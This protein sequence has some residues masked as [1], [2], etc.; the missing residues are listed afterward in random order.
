M[1]QQKSVGMELRNLG[2]LMKRFMSKNAPRPEHDS[3]FHNQGRRGRESHQEFCEHE[4]GSEHEHK[5]SH[6]SGPTHMHMMIIGYLVD[7]QNRDI[8]QKDIE[9][10]FSIRRPTATSMLQKMERH[11]I[12]TRVSVPGDARLKKIVVSEEVQAKTKEM[13]KHGKKLEEAITKGLT[14]EEIKT[15]IEIAEKIKNNLTE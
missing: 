9:K 10:E 2:I 15:F 1:S 7:N 6:G 4:H 8:F 12:I 11:G 3:G 5:H 13:N 14:D